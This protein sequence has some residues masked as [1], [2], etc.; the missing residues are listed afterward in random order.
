MTGF[1]GF[2][3]LVLATLL[4][5]A[6]LTILIRRSSRQRFQG[7]AE[8]IAVAFF[9]SLAMFYASCWANGS[10]TYALQIF[11]VG[12]CLVA[13]FLTLLLKFV[14]SLT[15]REVGRTALLF[16]MVKLALLASCL[17]YT[18]PS[19]RDQRGSRMPSSA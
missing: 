14:T 1:E 13:I 18:S 3:Y 16:A 4:D 6:I 15:N 11:L 2:G 10:G 8:S 12:L 9:S 7:W 5:T 17:L 19:P